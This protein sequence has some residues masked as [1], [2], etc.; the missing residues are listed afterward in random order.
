MTRSENAAHISRV[1][2]EKR[3]AAITRH[4]MAK[5]GAISSEW[6]IWSSMRQRCNNQWSKAYENYGARGITVC[7]RWGSFDNF[8]AD[9]GSRPSKAHSIDRV[10][11]D[12]P[13]S[14][15]NCRW[16]TRAEQKANQRPRKDAIWIEYQGERKTRDQWARDKGIKYTTLCRRLEK[17]WPIDRALDTPTRRSK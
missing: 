15:D 5:R 3:A 4:G 7:D 16:A 9:M 8:I 10:D 12:G 17:G 2:A 13:Y 14:P 6:R 1:T 11:N